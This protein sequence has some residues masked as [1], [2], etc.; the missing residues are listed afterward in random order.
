MTAEQSNG[1]EEPPSS[2]P[3]DCK[4]QPHRSGFVL[5]RDCPWH[6]PISGR[7]EQ[8]GRVTGEA[9]D[10]ASRLL[11]VL[12]SIRYTSGVQDPTG[13]DGYMRGTWDDIERAFSEGRLTGEEYQVIA[14]S[15]PR[16]TGARP[17]RSCR[18]GS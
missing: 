7:L 17:C 8:G 16:E 14:S 18:C 10:D 15:A 6:F 12:A 5:R 9:M 13:G 4:C 2:R 3:R 11:G 1:V